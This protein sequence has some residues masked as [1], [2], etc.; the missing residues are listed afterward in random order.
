MTH[1]NA[2]LLR[3][4]YE[5][6]GNGDLEPLLGALTDDISWRDSSLAPLAGDYTGKE[7]VLGFFG[8]MMEVYGGTLRLA[9]VDILADENH[10]VVLTREEGASGGESVK[11]SGVH[12]WAFRDG[13]CAQ[14]HAYADGDYH[15]FWSQRNRAAATISRPAAAEGAG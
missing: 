1:P 3:T 15:R 12:L 11:W 5:A 13:R 4:T 9:V 8:K 7:E 6:F 2:E 14:F 10:G